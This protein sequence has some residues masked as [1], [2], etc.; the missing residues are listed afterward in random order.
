M[1]NN[2]N[3][4]GLIVMLIVG[5]IA[6]IALVVW[7]FS[8]FFGLD[9]ETGGKVLFRLIVLAVLT[10]L[11]WKL[12]EDFDPIQPGNTWP[13]L[14]ALFLACWWPALDYRASLQYPAFFAEMP[15]VWWDAWYTKWGM[16]AAAIV[17]G[18]WFKNWR[19]DD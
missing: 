5:A 13:I 18:Y 9:M 4:D 14:V 3:N 8:T 11:L 16:S 19:D 7:E 17:L 1:S 6:V 2:G 10:A 12:G 15:T